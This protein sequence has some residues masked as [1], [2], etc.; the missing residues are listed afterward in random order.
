MKVTFWD[1]IKLLLRIYSV[2]GKMKLRTAV[3]IFFKPVETTR[4]VE[5]SYLLKFL[6]KYG[7]NKEIK[8][9][10]VSSPFILSYILSKQYY[11]LKTD[12]NEDEKYYIKESNNLKF[13]IED[14]TKLSFEDNTFDLVYSISV[15]EHIYQKFDVAINEMIRVTKHGGI[16]YLTFPVSNNYIEEWIDYDIYSHQYKNGR[17]TFFQY[18]FDEVNL[19]KILDSLKGVEILHK[20]I[21]W[22]RKNGKYDK[23]I[24]I[25]KKYPGDNF[26]NFILNSLINL[27]AGFS[28]LETVPEGFES[29]KSFGNISIVLK[30]I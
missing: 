26:K 3:K 7:I 1:K 16:L 14:A 23:I 4:Y 28:L 6:S 25:L 9:L 27:Y 10:D 29:N 18:R 2:L 19:E 12:I 15:I 22:E 13:K 21:F 5:F 20:D 8:I 11:V 30:K 24:D 17:K